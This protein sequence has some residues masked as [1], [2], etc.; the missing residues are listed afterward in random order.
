MEAAVLGE[1]RRV[2]RPAHGHVDLVHGEVVGVLDG[3]GP[4]ELVDLERTQVDDAAV[5]TQVE[6]LARRD[7]T[8]PAVVPLDLAFCEAVALDQVGVGCEPLRAFPGAGLEE[9]GAQVLLAGEV[10][11]HLEV[12]APLPLLLGVDDPIGLV[13]ALLG[14]RPDVLVAALVGVEA[15]DVRPVD[16]DDPRIAVGHPLC[17]DLGHAR[18]F[19]DP[20]GGG[21]PE[22]PDLAG[23]AQAGHAVWCQ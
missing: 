9:H 20:D 14:A 7:G 8:P 17:D 18:A 4:L 21:R 11:T 23:L 10:G 13:E 2:D 12:A 22:V 6:V 15:G 3:T 1:P 16:V 5:L 19:L